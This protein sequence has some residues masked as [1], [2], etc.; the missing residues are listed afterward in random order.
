MAGS[1]SSEKLIETRGLSLEIG[2]RLV[3]EDIEFDLLP[4]QSVGLV[5]PSGSGKTS[6]LHVCFGR[7]APTSGSITVFGVAPP[8]LRE[9]RA[10]IGYAPQSGFVEYPASMPALEFVIQG[11]LPPDLARRRPPDLV[12]RAH[13]M[14]RMTGVG[15]LANR[16]IGDFDAVRYCRLRLARALVNQPKLL[17]V[18]ELGAGLLMAEWGDLYNS[19]RAITDELGMALLLVASDI[20]PIRDVVP[21]IVCLNRTIH[22]RGA[23]SEVPRE[24]IMRAYG[25]H[26][27]V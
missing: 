5:G 2:P 16:P 14:M 18:D 19:V 22:Y 8:Q 26:Y 20:E 27:G 24:A 15:E 9:K 3:L 6:F 13:I 21:E 7:L 25:T 11:A 1:D 17:I 12:Q 23:P 4:G 10:W